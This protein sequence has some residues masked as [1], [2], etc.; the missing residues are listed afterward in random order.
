MGGQVEKISGVLREGKT[1]EY[2]A[3]RKSV[4]NK[5]QIGKKCLRN[6]TRYDDMRIQSQYLKNRG[7]KI[8]VSLRQ[9]W[10]S[11]Q[12]PGTLRLHGD[13]LSHTSK[14]MRLRMWLGLKMGNI[15]TFPS[16]HCEL[17]IPL[18]KS[19]FKSIKTKKKEFN[20]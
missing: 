8:S 6:L 9:S 12:G 1:S 2:I 19:S 4:I 7:R 11:W 17:K 15:C 14:N 20:C 13:T 10:S 16:V 5:R 18:K 3:W